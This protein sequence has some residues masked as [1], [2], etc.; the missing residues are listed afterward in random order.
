MKAF[1]IF[2]MVI[3]SVCF[4][5]GTGSQGWSAEAQKGMAIE[6]Q[7]K[8][9]VIRDSTLKSEPPPCQRSILP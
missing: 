4:I 9:I 1:K 2:I 7:K 6:P 8:P 5:I 3:I